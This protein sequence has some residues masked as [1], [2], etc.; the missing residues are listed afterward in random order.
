MLR[1]SGRKWSRFS[2]GRDRE[3]RWDNMNF[4]HSR[5]GNARND[6][7]SGDFRSPGAR[8]N[9][10]RSPLDGSARISHQESPFD[11]RRE[12]QHYRS[13]PLRQQ[14]QFTP[15]SGFNYPEARFFS[16]SPLILQTSTSF[17]DPNMSNN[18]QN[19]NN[20]NSDNNIS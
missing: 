13:E 16:C 7:R 10:A 6:S 4:P 11:E 19:F 20:P 5:T 12:E 15:S 9:D 3:S 18:F 14:L 1:N 2:G 17:Y 8:K